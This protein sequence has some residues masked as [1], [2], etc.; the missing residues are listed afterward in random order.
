MNGT[1]VTEA[2]AL[3]L[4]DFAPLPP[5]AFGPALNEHDYHVGQVVRNLYWVTEGTYQAGSTVFVSQA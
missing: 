3:S 2:K 1:A 5:S 4:P